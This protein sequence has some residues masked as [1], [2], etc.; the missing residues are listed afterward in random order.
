MEMVEYEA[1]D[2]PRQQ[3]ECLAKL[4]Q[5]SSGSMTTHGEGVVVYVYDAA[6][7]LLALFKHKCEEY[8]FDRKLRTLLTPLAAD[9]SPISSHQASA[10]G[11]TL[12]R[13]TKSLSGAG[14][15]RMDQPTSREDG[16]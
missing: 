13:I 9:L 4:A 14:F 8:A 3:S 7:R 6:S 1:F 16:S 2:L 12:W 11:R 5:I 15:D 10:E